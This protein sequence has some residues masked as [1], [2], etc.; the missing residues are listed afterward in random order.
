MWKVCGLICLA[1][2]G[3]AP[4]GQKPVFPV[5]GEV[6]VQSRPAEGALIVFHPQENA[7]FPE[8]TAGFPRALVA[9]DGTFHLSTYGD[10]DGAP[11]GDYVVLLQWR[12]P[13]DGATAEERD[14]EAEI[15]D[16]L[17]GKYMD[18]A[19]SALRAKVGEQPNILPRYN[20]N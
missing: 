15:P 7:D 1:A 5:E 16:R 12:K 17:G 6:F 18:P 9:A 3:C 19:N 20:L 14:P 13:P 10:A 4:S 8:W 11:A 2:A